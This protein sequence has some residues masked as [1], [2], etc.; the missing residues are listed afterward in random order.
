MSAT[1]TEETVYV[2][3][4]FSQ[5]EHTALVALCEKEKRSKA[6]QVRLLCEPSL[7]PFMTPDKTKR[8]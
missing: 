5:A 8:K 4:P 1:A 7:R 2:S 3:V 6:A